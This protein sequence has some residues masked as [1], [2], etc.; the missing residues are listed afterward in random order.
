MV[1]AWV[2][3]PLVDVELKSRFTAPTVGG[4]PVRV[5]VPLAPKVTVSHEGTGWVSVNG[6]GAGKPTAVTVKDS[7]VLT[8]TKAVRGLAKVGFW[9]NVSFT[10]SLAE[11]GVALPL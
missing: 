10:V 8:A 6:P 1:S 4:V 11:D 2:F 5:A 9:S 7:G 3:V